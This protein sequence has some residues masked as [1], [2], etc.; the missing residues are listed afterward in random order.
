MEE[1]RGLLPL[2]RLYRKS[3][4]PVVASEPFTATFENALST[5]CFVFPTRSAFSVLLSE[6][7]C[8]PKRSAFFPL[9][10]RGTRSASV[11]TPIA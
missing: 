9:P 3:P 2:S 4:G 7:R 5:V 8:N 10:F 6:I 11:V 1:G